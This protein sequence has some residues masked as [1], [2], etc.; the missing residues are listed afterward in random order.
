M[1]GE[2]R[3]IRE[4]AGKGC[5]GKTRT[6]AHHVL[7]FLQPAHDEITVRAGAEQATKVPEE[8]EAVEP[9]YLFQLL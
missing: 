8:C 5:F 2:M 4:T 9:A 7:A 6:S 1:P 3:L